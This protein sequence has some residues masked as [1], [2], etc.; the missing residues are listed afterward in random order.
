MILN[1]RRFIIVSKYFRCLAGQAVKRKEINRLE[2]T[3]AQRERELEKANSLAQT[4][5]E[6][7]AKYARRVGDLEQE[8]KSLLT[9]KALK[10]NA[11]IQK[12]SD[13]LNE[14]K[15]QCE[16]LRR[17]KNELERKLEETLAGND[18]NMRQII[19]EQEKEAVGEYN[20]EYLEIHEKAVQRV[21]QEAQIEIVQLS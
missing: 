21:R 9:D 19:A 4:C 10:A 2:N 3:L 1:N 12:L 20:K 8:L 7:A 14:V 11:E 17:E 16:T 13:H 18:E 15:E 6:E 5:Q